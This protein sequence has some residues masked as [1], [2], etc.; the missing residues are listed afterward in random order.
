[1]PKSSKRFV[2]SDE[3]VNRDGFWVKTSGIDLKQYE[4]NPIML[5]MHIRAIG[6]KEDIILALGTMTDLKVNKKNQ[7]TG[8][9]YFDDEDDFAMKVYRK[10]ENGTYRMTSAGLAPKEVRDDEAHLKDGAP[11]LSKS[12]LREVSIVDIGSNSNALSVTLYDEITNELITLN[13]DNKQT[14]FKNLK[15]NTMSKETIELSKVA[16]MLGLT[17]GNVNLSA[18]TDKITKLNTEAQNVVE[19]KADKEKLTKEVAKLKA[20]AA[21]KEIDAKLDK[22]ELEGRT[23]EGEREELKELAATNPEALDKLIAKRPVHLSA[24][25]RLAGAGGEA[26]KAD[27]L[28]ELSWD[29]AHESGQLEQIAEKYPDHFKA[30]KAAKYPKKK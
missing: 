27:P 10:V 28:L 4:K 9:P 6:G 20:E 15:T 30:L 19:L 13:A 18:I 12:E 25:Q 11:C 23:D 22:W 7:L 3:S 29:K 8:V 16:D 17:A 2:I 14:L 1:M 21:E 5:F 24:E 26:D